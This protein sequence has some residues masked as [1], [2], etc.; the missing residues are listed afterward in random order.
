[1]KGYERIMNAFIEV[2]KMWKKRKKKTMERKGRQ[3][4]DIKKD[5]NT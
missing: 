4:S 5:K 2:R 3:R 1:M